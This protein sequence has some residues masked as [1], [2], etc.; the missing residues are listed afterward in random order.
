MYDG[1]YA[2]RADVIEVAKDWVRRHGARGSS[3]SKRASLAEEIRGLYQEARGAGF[4]VAA[5]RQVIK[6]RRRDAAKRD[7]RQTIVDEYLAALGRLQLD[8]TRGRC[9]R[10]RKR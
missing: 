8:P 7:E 2:N 1:W 4:D 10:P 3:P 6:L 5:L 9:H